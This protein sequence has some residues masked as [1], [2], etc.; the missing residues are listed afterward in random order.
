MPGKN[1]EG[2]QRKPDPL[3]FTVDVFASANLPELQHLEPKWRGDRFEI[4]PAD[5]ENRVIPRRVTGGAPF[6]T[7]FMFGVHSGFTYPRDVH[8]ALTAAEKEGKPF[9]L[10]ILEQAPSKDPQKAR[11]FQDSVDFIEKFR[12]DALRIS[13]E[14]GISPDKALGLKAFVELTVRKIA[15]W[16]EDF[17]PGKVE[18]GIRSYGLD[19]SHAKVIKAL[20]GGMDERV[21]IERSR[22]AGFSRDQAEID[23]YKGMI[24]AVVAE[25]DVIAG[26]V[27]GDIPGWK[28]ADETEVPQAFRN[29]RITFGKA[30]LDGRTLQSLIPSVGNAHRKYLERFAYPRDRALVAAAPAILA[31][32]RMKGGRLKTLFVYG[33]GHA[34]GIVEG[35]L[36]SKLWD[37]HDITEIESNSQIR[38]VGF[39]DPIHTQLIDHCIHYGLALGEAEF[40]GKPIFD[41]GERKDAL[42]F[43]IKS[44]T[45]DDLRR[46]DG[47]IDG[48]RS[49]IRFAV[50]LGHLV[51]DKNVQINLSTE[52]KKEEC[53]NVRDAKKRIPQHIYRQLTT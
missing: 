32:H 11:G 28:P 13:K 52:H 3:F 37:D 23:I 30:F 12:A 17:D 21:R 39:S 14:T 50:L 46:I 47:K 19:D 53:Q 2:G 24:H 42:G 45:I 7:H 15:Y 8:N 40:G 38:T 20:L 10:V 9:N 4:A 22:I 49:I 43:R 5:G 25:H 6:D 33:G 51:G 18:A 34:A 1:E 29:I 35:A 26:A 41:I 16:V 27:E 44:A 48:L 31:G 36:N